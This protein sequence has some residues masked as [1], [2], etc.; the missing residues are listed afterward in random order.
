MPLHALKTH[1]MN[2]DTVPLILNLH[3]GDE[4]SPSSLS[5]LTTGT[6]K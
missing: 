4:C 2:G 5:H 3:N 6:K 1:S